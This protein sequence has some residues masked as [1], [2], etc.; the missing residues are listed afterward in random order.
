MSCKKTGNVFWGLFS[1]IFLISVFILLYPS[2]VHAEEKGVDIKVKYSGTEGYIFDSNG[3]VENHG[4][5]QEYD[6]YATITNN[7]DSTYVF[8]I[9]PLDAS[10]GTITD[11]YYMKEG[12]KYWWS[13]YTSYVRAYDKEI[14]AGESR[15]YTIMI[16]GLKP[17]VFD[18]M[19]GNEEY[20]YILTFIQFP[21][22]ENEGK[23][24]NLKQIDHHTV[25]AETEN[26]NKFYDGFYIYMWPEYTSDL[27]KYIFVDDVPYSGQKYVNINMP[28]WVRNYYY[29]K[30]NYKVCKGKKYFDF[31]KYWQPGLTCVD[32]GTAVQVKQNNDNSLIISWDKVKN[33]SKYELFMTMGDEFSSYKKIYETNYLGETKFIHTVEQ[34]ITYYYYVKVTFKN[35]EVS[36]KPCRNSGFIPKKNI[37]AKSKIVKKI[38]KIDNN[39]FI[40]GTTYNFTRNGT[41]YVAVRKN[42]IMTIYK[43]TGSEQLKKVK[44]IKLEKF[45]YFGCFYPAPDGNYY[46]AYGYNNKKEKNNKVVIKVAK[47]NAKWKKVKTAK[48]LGKSTNMFKG[49][50]KPFD[51][52]NCSLALNGNVLYMHTSR[53]MFK[54]KSD[55]LNHQSDISFQIN[56]KTMKV[57]NKSDTYA[58]HSFG[59]LALFKDNDLYLLDH[60]DAF[61]DGIKLT[62]VKNY[63]TDNEENVQ[64]VILKLD[65]GFG[66]SFTSLE[67]GKNHVLVLGIGKPLDNALKKVKGNKK[68]YINNMYLIT[69]DRKTNKHK[70]IWLTEFNPKKSKTT[71][72]HA[73]MVKITDDRFAIIYSTA[74]KNDNTGDSMKSFKTYYMVVDDSGNI[75]KKKRLKGITYSGYT[76]PILSNGYISWIERR[77]T[78]QY[79]YFYGLGY[80]PF[81]L[82]SNI[83]VNKTPVE[84]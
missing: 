2:V 25:R 76:Y 23:L 9:K 82:T 61:P 15:E 43:R 73:S 31:G 51:W 11:A 56:T 12:P 48:I 67:A 28:K 34:G 74:K 68:N 44:K 19:I 20:K 62:M 41:D 69:V 3:V 55:G 79:I 59:Q 1:I 10:C 58:S 47:Y 42:R 6:V 54:N 46:F 8:D 40:I 80:M 53:L 27:E 21:E 65:N 36:E 37:K 16:K 83:K 45:D 18:V 81:P 5:Q 49:I 33:A 17:S 66:S 72:A 52:S 32:P 22:S 26:I 75:I 60:G 64:K 78:T 84:Y 71:V 7:T 63:R 30:V 57:Q 77:D 13:H 29:A 35:G 50:V 38:K 24:K 70:F 4:I 39:P 14:P